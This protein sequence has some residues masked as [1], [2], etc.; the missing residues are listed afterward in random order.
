MC[1]PTKVPSTVSICPPDVEKSH[2]FPS[3]GDMT[4]NHIHVKYNLLEQALYTIL[5]TA[6]LFNL[7]FSQ[8]TKA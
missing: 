3:N 1:G 4:F 7:A 2:C 5:S 8:A 6:Y